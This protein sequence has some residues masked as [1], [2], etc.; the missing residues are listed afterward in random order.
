LTFSR[1][2]LTN[3]AIVGTLPPKIFKNKN[4][5]LQQIKI[6]PEKLFF[7]KRTWGLFFYKGIPYLV[8]EII[9]LKKMF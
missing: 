1:P 4:W 3:C 7:V 9:P 8:R 2:N 5:L 6:V